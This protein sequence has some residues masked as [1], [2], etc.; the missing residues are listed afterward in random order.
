MCRFT[1]RAALTGSVI[2]TVEVPGASTLLEH[3]ELQ[4]A[5][6]EATGVMMSPFDYFVS[7]DK[8]D[9]HNNVD[10]FVLYKHSD[11]RSCIVNSYDLVGRLPGWRR[12]RKEFRESSK[13]LPFAPARSA[14]VLREEIFGG[15]PVRSFAYHFLQGEL[16]ELRGEHAGR[17]PYKGNCFEDA[18]DAVCFKLGVPRREVELFANEWWEVNGEISDVLSALVAERPYQ[19]LF[20]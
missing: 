14:K 10:V 12:N 15:Q 4:A 5:F 13:V 19:N 6:F 11:P 2:T 3:Y 7:D 20:L 17:V 18:V 1:F 9:E 8:S 16:F